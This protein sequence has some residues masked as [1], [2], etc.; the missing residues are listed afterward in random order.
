MGFGTKERRRQ[1][2]A[3]PLPKRERGLSRMECLRGISI[4]INGCKKKEIEEPA[5]QNRWK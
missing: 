5:I 1:R 2:L 4:S 3:F